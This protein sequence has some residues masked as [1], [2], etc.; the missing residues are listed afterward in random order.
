M[1]LH[2]FK[3]FYEEFSSRK[4][5][6]QSSEAFRHPDNQT[7]NR[8]LNIPCYDHSRVNLIGDGDVDTYIHANYIPGAYDDKEYIYTQSPLPETVGDFWTMVWEQK[9]DI[10]VMVSCF[11]IRPFA[12]G[13]WYNCWINFLSVPG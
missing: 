8:Y 1:K 13:P 4:D 3:G 10:I 5:G 7:K 9:S 6:F 12:F 2:N 11:R